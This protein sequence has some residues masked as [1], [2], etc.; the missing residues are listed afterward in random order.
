M[1]QQ[2]KMLRTS[3]V[4]VLS[5]H[6]PLVLKEQ[7]DFLRAWRQM[8]PMADKG[9]ARHLGLSNFDPHH[10]EEFIDSTRIRPAVNQLPLYPYILPQAT[11]A[12]QYAKEQNI[13]FQSY[14]IA[15]SIVRATEQNG[16]LD[17]VL[18]S[19]AA[20]LSTPLLQVTPGQVLL[21]WASAKGT[22]CI[23]T[24][25]KQSRMAVSRLRILLR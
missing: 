15:S 14:E 7:G 12:L 4:D 17:P 20:Q 10:L 11:L 9:Y 21:A 16:P 13:V 25:S 6:T 19:I 24:S 5:I 18:D 3:Y 8:E 23:T 1:A 2:L 22:M